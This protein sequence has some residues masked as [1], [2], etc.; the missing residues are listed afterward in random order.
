MYGI[1]QEELG[2]LVVGGQTFWMLWLKL[3]WLG[4][5]RG[6][7]DGCDPTNTKLIVVVVV[8]FGMGGGFRM[9]P[10]GQVVHATKSLTIR[11]LIN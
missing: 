4:G 5:R 11:T 6:T 3:R 7:M 9:V 2:R 10:Y 1:K 8:L